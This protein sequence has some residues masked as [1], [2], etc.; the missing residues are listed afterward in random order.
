MD[1]DLLLTFG[2][3]CKPKYGPYQGPDDAD[4]V[5]ETNLAEETVPSWDGEQAASGLRLCN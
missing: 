3:D 4:D 1:K 5:D 2:E